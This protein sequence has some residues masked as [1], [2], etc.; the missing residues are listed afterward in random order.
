MSKYLVMQ[1]DIQ[2]KLK[3]RLDY[4]MWFSSGQQ[5]I[6][7]TSQ[8]NNKLFRWFAHLFIIIPVYQA[9]VS[10]MFVSFIK[11]VDFTVNDI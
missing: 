5:K 2:T 3:L 6:H 8:T 9:A 1:S 7:C 10:K 11:T 4:L